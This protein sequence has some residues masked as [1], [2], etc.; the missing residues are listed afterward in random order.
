MEKKHVCP[1]WLGYFLINP[2][3][4]FRH[5]PQKILGPYVSPGMHVVDFGCAMGYFSLP[6]ARMTGNNGKVYCLDIQEKMLKKLWKRAKK[7]KLDHRMEMQLIDHQGTVK[8]SEKSIDFILLFAV[9][10][11]VDKQAELFSRLAS[12]LKPGGLVLFAEPKGHVGQEDFE[13][14][15]KY[16]ENEGLSVI[17]ALQISNSHSVLFQKQVKQSTDFLYG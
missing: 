7:A 6:L 2:L 4:K 10:H 3:R 12:L 15:L 14:S 13:I 8:I 1:W 9:V 5:N 16:A 17:K 11:E